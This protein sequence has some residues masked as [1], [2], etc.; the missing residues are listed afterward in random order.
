MKKLTVT[1]TIFNWL[2]HLASI[3]CLYRSNARQDEFRPPQ[4]ALIYGEFLVKVQGY[5]HVC[6]RWSSKEKHANPSY[7]ATK[8]IERTS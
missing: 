6:S 7:K 1:S 8:H 5:D 3:S 4:A 2:T